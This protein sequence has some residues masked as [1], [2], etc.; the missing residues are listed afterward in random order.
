V[1]ILLGETLLQICGAAIRPHLKDVLALK[2][3]KYG[4]RPIVK[5]RPHPSSDR[6]SVT[7]VSRRPRRLKRRCLRRQML[8]RSRKSWS[9]T[10]ESSRP[11]CDGS[12]GRRTTAS[13]ERGDG[14]N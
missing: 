4:V 8:P 13:F 11:R 3:E 7:N 14:R 5:A 9:A 2:M 6:S 1:L 10:P 12:A